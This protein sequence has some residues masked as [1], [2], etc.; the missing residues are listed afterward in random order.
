M[1]NAYV[2]GPQNWTAGTFNVT[3]SPDTGDGNYPDTTYREEVKTVDASGPAGER[4]IDSDDYGTSAHDE[5]VDYIDARG[6]NDGNGLFYEIKVK[7]TTA[8]KTALGGSYFYPFNVSVGNTLTSRV[9]MQF[10]MN[11]TSGTLDVYVKG[12]GFDAT[13]ATVTDDN[14]WHTIKAQIRP[15]SD[16]ADSQQDGL[17]RVWYDGVLVDENLTSWAWV[18]ESTNPLFHFDLIYYGHFGLLPST[19][20]AIYTTSA[21]KQNYAFGRGAAADDRA[22]VVSDLTV[23]MNLDEQGRTVDEPNTLY[24]AGNLIV[25]GDTTLDNPTVSNPETLMNSI[26]TTGSEIVLDS[27]G[28]V[29]FVNG[30]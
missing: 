12:D 9:F 28:N 29:V 15:S 4:I 14:A 7:T 27:S 19:G 2:Y 13:S 23:L 26:V 1:A 11:L 8:A 20:G 10:R 30:S 17:V 3:G 16:N 22:K 21:P 6:L 24:V 18:A 5:T 25:T